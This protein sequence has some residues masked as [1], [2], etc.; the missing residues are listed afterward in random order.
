MT[1]DSNEEILTSFAKNMCHSG[2]D[3]SF[4]CKTRVKSDDFC[5][6]FEAK[7]LGKNG[8]FLGHGKCT[9]LRGII[10]CDRGEREN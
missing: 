7:I 4:V 2:Y 6:G 5:Y 10:E 9:V 3:E 1:V 8:F